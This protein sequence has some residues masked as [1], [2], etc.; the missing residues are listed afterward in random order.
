[1]VNGSCCWGSDRRVPTA[2]LTGGCDSETTG[3]TRVYTGPMPG[4]GDHDGK[5]AA[6]KHRPLSGFDPQAVEER[7]ALVLG[8]AGWPLS[9]LPDPSTGWLEDADA[10]PAGTDPWEALAVLNATVQAATSVRDVA[11]ARR[12][13]LV[14]LLVDEAGEG[15]PPWIAKI[16]GT[17]SAR[18][19]QLDNKGR[20]LRGIEGPR[21]PQVGGL[22]KRAAAPKKRKGE[23]QGGTSGAD[24][25]R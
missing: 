9:D 16:L 1:M 19:Q 5:K 24:S 21:R 6:V 7:R 22:P 14:S 17:S 25:A 15:S 18:V 23:G 2:T 4:A 13:R 11:A 3:S 20:Q 12:A 10:V 8:Y